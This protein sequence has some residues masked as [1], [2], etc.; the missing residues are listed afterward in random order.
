MEE[1]IFEKWQGRNELL[2]Q[3][4]NDYLFTSSK[5]A[6]DFAFERVKM[7]QNGCHL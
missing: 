3:S 2:Q 5:M 1:R 7:N 4:Y 6:K